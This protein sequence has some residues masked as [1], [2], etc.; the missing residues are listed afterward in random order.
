MKEIKMKFIALLSLNAMFFVS[1]LIA[2]FEKVF[3]ISFESINP[4]YGIIIIGFLF[5][6]LIMFPITLLS[7]WSFYYEKSE[8]V[9]SRE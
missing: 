1:G 9:A 7:K 6:I 5:F 2:I 8:K 4:N 3:G